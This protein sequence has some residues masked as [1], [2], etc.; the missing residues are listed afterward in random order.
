MK[1]I[2]LSANEKLIEEARQKARKERTTLNALF[3][4][5]LGSYVARGR[6]ASEYAELMEQ[7]SYV[8]PG[9]TF[10]REELNER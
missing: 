2:T 6:W 7:L 9:R 3:R 4:Q 8:R 1:N 10:S 5:W